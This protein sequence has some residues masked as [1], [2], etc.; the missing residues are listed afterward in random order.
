[1]ER[2]Y[3]DRHVHITPIQKDMKILSNQNVKTK[4]MKKNDKQLELKTL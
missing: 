1:M 3:M 2:R 4:L